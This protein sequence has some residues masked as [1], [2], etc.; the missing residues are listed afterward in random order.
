MTLKPAPELSRI[1]P[2]DAYRLRWKRKR[3]LWRSFRSRHQL[4]NLADHT[5]AIRDNDVL[6][7]V[8]LRNEAERLPFFLS[9]Y[10]RLGV[11]HFLIV[12]N[13]S[14]DGSVDLLRDQPDVSLW[15]TN[16]GYKASRFGLDWMTWLQMKYAHG[17]WCLMV[18]VD[19]ILIYAHSDNRDLTALTQWLDSTGSSAFGALML[20]LYAKGPAGAQEY[21]PGQDPSEVLPWFDPG[22]YRATRQSPL[23]NLWVQGGV[24][25]RVFFADQRR[26]SPTLNKLPLI[27]WKRS[28][29]YVNS[30]HSILP[31]AIN[32]AYSG[33]G[34]QA[35]SGVL[36]HGKFLPDVVARARTEKQRA[37]HFHTPRDFDGYYDQVIASPDLWCAQSAKLQGWQQLEELGLMSSGGW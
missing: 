3:L 36:L 17:H 32:G 21:Q 2:W 1:S 24:R 4:A 33:P 15:Q 9:H 11:G 10:R 34:G 18:D 5:G 29:A 35:A 16:A 30:C 13:G 12:D 8:V 19:E 27:K 6:A 14:D 25:E 7:V 26:R 23:G 20:D 31:R 28:Y 37:Q 22:P